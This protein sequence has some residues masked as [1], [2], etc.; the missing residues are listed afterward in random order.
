[1]FLSATICFPVYGHVLRSRTSQ[2]QE[3][4]FEHIYLIHPSILSTLVITRETFALCI[5]YPTPTRH[6]SFSFEYLS[7]HSFIK[8][9]FLPFHDDFVRANELRSSY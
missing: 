1:M 3:T 7:V 9:V 2:Q 8:I 4:S 6:A 5:F